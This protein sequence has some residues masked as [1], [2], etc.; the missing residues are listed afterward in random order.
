LID[1]QLTAMWNAGISTREISSVLTTLGDKFIS[2]NAIIGRAKRLNLEKH[3]GSHY[4]T[5]NPLVENVKRI[6][7]TPIAPY[8]T[9]TGT[10]VKRS[11]RYWATGLCQSP[12][13]RYKA[14]PNVVL[15]YGHSALSKARLQ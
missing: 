12:K 6:I 14:L 9:L 13:C 5:S 15:C 1:K 11:E 10:P 8:D 2:R 3:E 7:N 4:E